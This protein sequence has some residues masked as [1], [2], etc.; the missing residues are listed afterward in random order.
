MINV[1]GWEKYIKIFHSNWDKLDEKYYYREYFGYKKYI[2]KFPNDWWE[3]YS[4]EEFIKGLEPFSEELLEVHYHLSKKMDAIVLEYGSMS[5]AKKSN[6]TY[7]TLVRAKDLLEVLYISSKET[8]NLFLC[9]F[10][11]DKLE[12][13]FTDEK[14]LCSFLGKKCEMV[15][16]LRTINCVQN[17]ENANITAKLA[18]WI[19]FLDSEEYKYQVVHT[20]NFH[21]C[22]KCGGENYL[23]KDIFKTLSKSNTAEKYLEKQ[24]DEIKKI[25]KKYLDNIEEAKKFAKQLVNNYEIKKDGKDRFIYNFIYNYIVI[26]K[27][28]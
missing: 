24:F 11:E 18:L 13:D 15:K 1:L 19:N 28:Y 17:F 10:S 16:L 9:N 8:I 7:K 22:E 2:E 3:L 23:V 6:L 21:G 14:L 12:L 5:E 27:S 20:E 26:G 4:D 25:R